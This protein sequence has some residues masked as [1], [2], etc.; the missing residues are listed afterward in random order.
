MGEHWLG[1]ENRPARPPASNRRVASV[2]TCVVCERV[3]QWSEGNNPYFITEFTQSI[4]VVGDHQFYKGYSLL[5]LK[6]HIRE[7]HELSDS[8][9]AELSRELMMA[10]KALVKTFNPWKMNHESL[11]NTEEHVHWHITPRYESDPR[12]HSNPYINRDQFDGFLIN[13][14]EARRIAAAIRYNL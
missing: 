6:L 9:Y 13:H 12:H 4:F 10:N 14:D 11:G 7:L 5:L 2:R 1:A 8:Q 3:K